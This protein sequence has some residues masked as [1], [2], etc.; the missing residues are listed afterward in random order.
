[1]AIDHFSKSKMEVA[2]AD[3]DSDSHF[4]E[5]EAKEEVSHMYHCHY[6]KKYVGEKFSMTKAHEVQ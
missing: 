6:G 3:E 5:E 1:M 2:M 4:S